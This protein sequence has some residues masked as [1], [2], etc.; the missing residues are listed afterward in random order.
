MESFINSLRMSARIIS[1]T[2]LEKKRGVI[3]LSI[4]KCF[5][6]DNAGIRR[7]ATLAQCNLSSKQMYPIKPSG[8]TGL[9]QNQ[10]L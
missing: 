4:S 7:W 10:F 2:P 6:I 9:A 5:T 1:V 8:I 3:R